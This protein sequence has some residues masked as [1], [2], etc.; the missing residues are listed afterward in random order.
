MKVTPA[1]GQL[2]NIKRSEIRQNANV[3]NSNFNLYFNFSHHC[4]Q[5]Q[6]FKS[7]S[8]GRCASHSIVPFKRLSQF[9][10][11]LLINYIHASQHCCS[12]S[13]S[14]FPAVFI[15]SPKLSVLLKIAV[16]PSSLYILIVSTSVGFSDP[17][18]Y[19]F[20]FAVPRPIWS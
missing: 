9:C 20:L 10:G 3:T 16:H 7:L 5:E 6:M 11:T 13:L 14:L 18:F 4:V 1:V 17:H 19:C 8:L 15:S 12:L 2:V